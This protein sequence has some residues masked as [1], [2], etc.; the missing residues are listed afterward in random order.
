[1]TARPS[2]AFCATVSRLFIC[3]LFFLFS[4][5]FFSFSFSQFCH[6]INL[7]PPRGLHFSFQFCFRVP[8]RRRHLQC[9]SS[10]RSIG[11]AYPR[12]HTTSCSF[13]APLC[14][15][16][17]HYPIHAITVPHYGILVFGHTPI[18]TSS[19]PSCRVSPHG[20]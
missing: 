13:L 9:L 1:M 2:H 3:F 11:I 19:D 18:Y 15:V 6:R 20:S 14:D 8:T 17:C 4:S 12:F 7:L 16:L 10:G 5:F